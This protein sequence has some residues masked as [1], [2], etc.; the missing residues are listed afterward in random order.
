[1]AR[2]VV[3]GVEE[4]VERIWSKDLPTVSSSSIVRKSYTT[5]TAF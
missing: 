2:A 1:M 5:N 3:Q 4:D